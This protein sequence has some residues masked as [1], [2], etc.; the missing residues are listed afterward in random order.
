MCRFLAYIGPPVLAEDLLY[1]PKFSL[2]VAQ[3]MQAEE[4]SVAVNGDGFGIGWYIPEL[5]ETPCVFRSVK[6]AWSDMNLK[7]L[8]KKVLSPLIFAHVRA[9]SPGSL[10][11]EGNSHPF[12][13][14]KLMFMHNGMVGEFNKIRRPILRRLNDIAYEAVMGSTDSEH[15]FGLFLNHIDDPNGDITTDDMVYAM[16]KMLDDFAALHTENN[17]T[18]HAYLNLCVTNGKSIVATRYTTNPLVQPSSLYYMYGKEYN[19]AD[20]DCRMIQS[21]SHP[22]CIVLASEPFTVRRS[23]WMKVERNAMI[24][25]D[26]KLSIRFQSIELPIERM[27]QQAEVL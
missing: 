2:I 7:S 8:A 27:M 9:A 11:E 20:G 17:L 5:D 15:L 21:D 3:S 22:T 12:Q 16:N 24:I 18:K 10:V 14:G 13:C 25:I 19:C 4:M 6:P 26:E 1:K 23:D